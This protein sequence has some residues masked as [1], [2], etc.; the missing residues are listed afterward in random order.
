MRKP[1][2]D[3]GWYDPDNICPIKIIIETYEFQSKRFGDVV[4]HC[5][6]E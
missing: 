4:M 5:I 6:I 2:L 3:V 1:L